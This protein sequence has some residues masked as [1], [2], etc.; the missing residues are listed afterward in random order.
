M[1][2]IVVENISKYFWAR[3]TTSES[4]PSWFK[5]LIFGNSLAKEVRVA[6]ITA[7][8]SVSFTVGK[9][10]IFGILGPNGSG[11]TTLLKIL[12]TALL[13]DEG[14]AYICGYSVVKEA[15]KVRK[16]ISTNFSLIVNSFWTARQALE[17]WCTLNDVDSAEAVH[18]VNEVLDEVGLSERADE[19]VARYSMGMQSRLFLA[20][21]LMLDR[22]VYLLDE[23]LLGID[24]IAAK[25]LRETIKR[26]AREG[27]TV[28]LATN[29][30]RDVEELCDKVCVLYR[31]RVV[32][33]E[34]PEVLKKTIG[35]YECVYV[36]LSSLD[37]SVLLKLTDFNEVLDLS[38]VR[39]DNLL[40]TKIITND[41]IK[42][43]Y[44][45]LDLVKLNKGKIISIKIAEPILEDALIEL[46]KKRCEYENRET[47]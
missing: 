27:K 45:L 5:R 30:I 6:R 21:S 3:V 2:S 8:K 10:E 32:A 18:K 23:P 26:K 40:E 35:A 19:I 14:D 16:L 44:L 46:L 34:S 33:L 41:T 43:L 36:T 29:L 42:V 39:Q 9:G 13:P 17:Y 1:E 7:L 22:E 37:S 25:E 11:K 31:S 15:S 38:I 4:K 28:V 20:S 47:A 24:P 12:A